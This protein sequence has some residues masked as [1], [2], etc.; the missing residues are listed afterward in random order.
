MSTFVETLKHAFAVRRTEAPAAL[1]AAL[2]RFARGVVERRM[3][4]PAIIFLESVVPLSFLGSQA[5]CA[6]SPVARMLGAPGDF[7]EIAE[8][9]EDRGTVRRLALRIEELAASA[10]REGGR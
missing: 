2:E 5:M 8:A 4:T 3:E 9:L 6:A 10:A 1:P 7:E